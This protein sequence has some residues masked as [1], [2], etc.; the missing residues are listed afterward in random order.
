MNNSLNEGNDQF[1][2]TIQNIIGKDIIETNLSYNELQ[3]I[4][5]SKKIY[6]VLIKLHSNSYFPFDQLIDIQLVGTQ[7][8]GVFNASRFN[9]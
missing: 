2:A 9:H 4:V 5:L 3:I 8:S 7:L 1:L 6:D